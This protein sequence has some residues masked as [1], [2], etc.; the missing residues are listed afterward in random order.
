MS[1]TSLQLV[2]DQ[3]VD[4]T[5]SLGVPEDEQ[6]VETGEKYYTFHI[7]HSRYDGD[8]SL[9]ELRD[10]RYFRARLEEDGNFVIYEN[11][12]GDIVDAIDYSLQH[13]QDEHCN[14]NYY[15]YDADGLAKF[16][17][18]LAEARGVLNSDGDIKTIHDK[19][20]ERCFNIIRFAN[21]HGY[22][23]NFG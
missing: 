3:K 17:A 5:F 9:T 23:V 11:V 12:T 8:K 21:K 4:T 14:G 16:I 20:I 13:V 1:Q 10:Y 15:V 7:A 2:R 22:G 18:G 6:T 19:K